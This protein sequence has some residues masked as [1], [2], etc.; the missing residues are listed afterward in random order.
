MTISTHLLSTLVPLNGL[1]KFGLE[2]VA[3]IAERL[4]LKKDRQ[5]YPIGS[6]DDF[7][8][9]LLEGQVA[10]LDRNGREALIRANSDQA[11]FAFGNLKPR[12]SNARVRSDSACLIRF[13]NQHLETLITWGE[14]LNGP[15]SEFSAD[16]ESSL[17]VSELLDDGDGNMDTAWL[18]SLLCSPSFYDMP[19]ENVQ[20]IGQRMTPVEVKAGDLVIRQNEPGDYYYVIREGR[21]RVIRNDVSIAELRPLTPFGEEAL[22]SGAPRNASVEMITDGLLMRL[23]KQDFEHLLIPRL[24]N[25]INLENTIQLAKQGAV[26]LDVRSAEEFTKRRLLRSIN[27]PLFMLRDRMNKLDPGRP[28]IVYCDSGIRSASGAFL[29]SQRGFRAYLLSEPARAFSNI[30][31]SATSA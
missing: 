23:S 10:L 17:V 11:R 4:D 28:Y 21:A 13:N 6:K 15:S 25:R 2:R 31:S 26:L 7:V 9:Y 19:P 22:A 1:D 29:L 8:Y 3:K 18:M 5:I 27:I 24:L 30:A 20:K 16:P 12:P 14:Q